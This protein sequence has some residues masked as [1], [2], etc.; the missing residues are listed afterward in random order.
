[1]DTVQQIIGHTGTV[2]ARHFNAID[3]EVVRECLCWI[4]CDDTLGTSHPHNAVQILGKAHDIGPG[5]R[6]TVLVD[7]LIVGS[8]LRTRRQAV[9]GN[10]EEY[11]H[12]EITIGKHL[13]VVIVVAG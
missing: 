8:L 9:I 2:V 5:K 6:L 7:E 3:P 11:R 12:F 10:P 13:D 4:E 1:M